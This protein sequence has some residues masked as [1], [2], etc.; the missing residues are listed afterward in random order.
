M[1]AVG[2]RATL[3]RLPVCLVPSAAHLDLRL[4]LRHGS[5]AGKFELSEHPV[6]LGQLALALEDLI[7]HRQLIVLRVG[8]CFA[9]LCS[10]GR[11]GGGAG[12]EAGRTWESGQACG[13]G[14]EAGERGEN[15]I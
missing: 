5:P 8:I 2:R 3:G 11:F 7:G 6:V 9:R 10:R 4:A 12:A 1:R 14:V 13:S 15:R